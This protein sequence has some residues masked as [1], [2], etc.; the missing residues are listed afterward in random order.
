M[1]RHQYFLTTL[2]AHVDTRFRNGNLQPIVK[3]SVSRN[4]YP[5]EIGRIESI[6]HTIYF[7]NFHP[8]QIWKIHWTLALSRGLYKAD[9]KTN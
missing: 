5:P 4:I 8:T 1:C 9:I 2:R 3:S 7:H 6:R